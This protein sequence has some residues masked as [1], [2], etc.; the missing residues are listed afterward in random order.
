MADGIAVAAVP[1]SGGIA[2]RIGARIV[3]IGRRSPTLVV[4]AL[5]LL[6]FALMALTHPWLMP[7]DPIAV[8]PDRVLAPPGPEHWFGTDGTPPLR[9]KGGS[10]N[11]H[12][13]K[14]V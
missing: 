8:N 13:S 14:K 10:A 11:S 7:H 5:I 6:A 3:G 9:T 12:P 1:R 4:G 2:G